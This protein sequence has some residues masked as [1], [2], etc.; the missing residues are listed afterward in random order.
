[1][2]KKYY[3]AFKLALYEFSGPKY[4]NHQRLLMSANYILLK[5]CK[6][7][8]KAEAVTSRTLVKEIANLVI[9]SCLNVRHESAEDWQKKKLK[10]LRSQFQI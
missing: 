8:K 1:M 3:F 5:L 7:F 4:Q 9:Q 2:A 6:I 10:I